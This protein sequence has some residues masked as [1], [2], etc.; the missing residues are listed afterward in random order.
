MEINSELARWL[1]KAAL[2]PYYGDLYDKTIDTLDFERDDFRGNP[3]FKHSMKNRYHNQHGVYDTS[4]Y[5]LLSIKENNLDINTNIIRM[6]RYKLETGKE[7]NSSDY[8]NEIQKS[9]KYNF[10]QKL[11]F[12][13]SFIKLMAKLRDKRIDEILND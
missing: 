10:N 5:F 9:Y 12:E 3:T 2:H 8:K 11:E 1:M 6:I 13:T 7:W 4:K